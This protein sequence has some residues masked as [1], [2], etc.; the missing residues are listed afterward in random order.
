M[1]SAPAAPTRP[2][3]WPW[4][5]VPMALAAWLRLRGLGEAGPFVDEGANIL[6]A[7]DPRVREA[8]EPLGQGRPWLVW[9]FRPAGWFPAHALETARLMSVLAGLATMIFLG[10]TLHR[11]AGRGAVLLGLWCWALLPFAV[12]HERLALQDPFITALLAAALALLVAGASSRR[13]WL[14]LAAG[15]IGGIAFLLKISAL[16][17]LPWIGLVYVAVQRVGA[18]PV[19]ERRLGFIVMGAIL[20][21]LTLGPNLGQLGSKLGRYDALPTLADGG[22][23]GSALERL[24]VWLGWYW[25]YGGWPLAVLLVAA[26]VL[27]AIYR[28]AVAFG[29]AAAWVAAVLVTSLFYHNTYARY[30]LPDHLPLILFLAVAIGPHL[31]AW[32]AAGLLAVPLARWGFVGAQIGTAPTLSAVPAGE[33]VQY[34]SGPWSGRS[35]QAVQKFLTNHA[36]ANHVQCVVL[37]HRFLRPGCYGLLLA[38]LGDPRINVVPVTIYDKAALEAVRPTMKQL[39]T[40]K[41]LAFFLLYEGSLYPAHPWLDQP[42]GPARR[43]WAEPRGAGEEFTLYQF[44]P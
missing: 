5:A 4:F 28:N 13:P 29:C 36:D 43:V 16:L 35:V 2:P 33:I 24:G 6:T 11:L 22:F 30:A 8:F 42:G 7:L 17:A 10:W 19:L 38:E 9:L 14:W 32:W 39:A 41:R 18:R 20:P 26:L 21:V 31:R 1:P 44:E 40:G 23:S 3:V 34:Y 25:G 37:T 12:W 15:V 27:A